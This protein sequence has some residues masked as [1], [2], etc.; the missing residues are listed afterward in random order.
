MGTELHNLS[1]GEIYQVLDDL[2]RTRH[3]LHKLS[4]TVDCEKCVVILKVAYQ[5]IGDIVSK[6][7][8]LVKDH[9]D[10]DIECLN[11]HSM[12]LDAD[13]QFCC[14]ACEKEYNETS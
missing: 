11:C 14:E 10:V 7:F 2:N 6:V 12:A 3:S 9:D 4:K 5:G 1:C 8:D 13:Y